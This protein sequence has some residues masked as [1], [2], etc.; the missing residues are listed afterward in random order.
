[1]NRFVEPQYSVYRTGT[2]AP[3]LQILSGVTFQFP[4]RVK[5][6]LPQTQVKSEGGNRVLETGERHCIRRPMRQR[7]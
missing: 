3:I 5:G 2:R 7:L 1:M 6:N 4:A